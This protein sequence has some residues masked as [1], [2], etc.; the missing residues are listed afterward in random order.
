MVVD[1]TCPCSLDVVEKDEG[2]KYKF[3]CNII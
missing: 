3:V 1:L 2:K